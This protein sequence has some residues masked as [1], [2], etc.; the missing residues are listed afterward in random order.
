MEPQPGHLEFCFVTCTDSGADELARWPFLPSF[1]QEL[2]GSWP[3]ASQGQLEDKEPA[4]Q[5]WLLRRREL[6]SVPKVPPAQAMTMVSL[7]T[8]LPALSRQSSLDPA[9]TGP[10]QGVQTSL[11]KG[12]TSLRVTVSAP[13]PHACVSSPVPMELSAVNSTWSGR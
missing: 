5:L 12:H 13:R 1:I 4:G 8:A 2:R 6:L 3:S 11:H 7:W 10:F 9:V